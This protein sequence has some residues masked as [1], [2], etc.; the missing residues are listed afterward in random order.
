M[1]IRL[2]ILEWLLGIAHRNDKRLTDEPYFSHLLRVAA[3]FKDPEDRA[4]ALCHDL[5]ENGHGKYMLF[6]RIMFSKATVASIIRINRDPD[7][8]YMEYIEKQLVEDRC[9]R[10]KMRDIFDNLHKCPNPSL[11]QRYIKALHK[12][13]P[14]SIIM[15]SSLGEPN[16]PKTVIDARIHKIVDKGVSTLTTKW[17]TCE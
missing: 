2:H 5:I 17:K 7:D 1:K 13:Q 6:V 14:D 16:L 12:L 3:E 4:V 11:I 9:V 10:I 8:T 15:T